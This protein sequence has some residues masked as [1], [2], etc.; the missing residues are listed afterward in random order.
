MIVY[1]TTK[2]EDHIRRAFIG[3]CIC[4]SIMLGACLVGSVGCT[5]A[6]WD[7]FGEVVAP[8]PGKV[9]EAASEATAEGS[10]WT[11]LEL[12]GALAAGIGGPA[13]TYGIGRTV[14]RG[15]GVW[16]K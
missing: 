12:L 13:G 1:P 8:I 2:R 15:M 3:G 5:N 11:W 7:A 6:Q 4:A 16:K 10:E 14:M 9:Q